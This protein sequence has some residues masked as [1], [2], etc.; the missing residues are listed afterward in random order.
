MTDSTAP[1]RVRLPWRRPPLNANDRYGHW[2]VKA[3]AVRDTRATAALAFRTDADVMAHRHDPDHPARLRVQLGYTP[4]DRRRRDTDNLLPT[5]KA[6]ADAAVDVGL[7]PDDVPEFMSKPEPII[8]APNR[9]DPHLWVEI[10]H[11]DPHEIEEPR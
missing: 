7:A 1:V 4:R 9:D 2:A 6:V 10:S 5:L 3:A 11:T 8:T